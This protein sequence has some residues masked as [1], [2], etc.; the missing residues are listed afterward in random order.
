MSSTSRRGEHGIGARA[1]VDDTGVLRRCHRR[2][3]GSTCR[4]RAIGSRADEASHAADEA[5]PPTCRAATRAAFSVGVTTRSR[6]PCCSIAVRAAA[7][8]VVLPAPA[9]P[10]MTTRS[11]PAASVRTTSRWTGSRPASASVAIGSRRA[12][13]R[14]GAMGEAGGEVG[15]DL[16]DVLR[17]QGADMLGHPGAV[18]KRD[19][20]V[21]RSGGQVLGK[22]KPNRGGRRRRSHER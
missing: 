5:S 22:L 14:R 17:R 18:D 19:A 15:F 8:V 16:E 12:R 4:S 20:R 10:S 1:G 9:A 3:A 11:A 7:K 21:D 6:P 2:E 13:R